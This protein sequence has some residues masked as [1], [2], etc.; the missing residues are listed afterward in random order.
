MDDSKFLIVGSNGQLGTALQ[1]RYPNARAVDKDD[2]DITD[3]EKVKDFDWGNI[4]T[5]LNTAAY[6]DVDGAESP[7]GRAIAWKVNA[8]GVENLS[9]VAAGKDL[10]LVHISTD[11]VFDGT[12]NSHTEDEAFSP[13]SEYGRSKAA[14]DTAVQAVPKHYILRTS[15]LIGEGQNFVRTMLNLGQKGVGPTVVADQI[16]RPTFTTQLVDA[17]HHLLSTNYQ[18]PT[19]GAPA[20]YGTYNVS[21][22]GEPVSWAGFTRAIFTEAGFKL[23][24]TDISTTDYYRDKPQSAP[25]P[26]SSVFDLSKIKAT[27][28]QLR[29]WHDDLREYIKK[30]LEKQ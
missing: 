17:I 29:D 20:P 13:L 24:V 1:Q 23:A 12:N 11:Y 25:R 7:E 30:E 15:W 26:L 19:T 27:G 10:A 5:V 3:I 2:L 9:K 22:D 18:L 4:T 8:E 21:N 16:G 28:L 14:G 6:T